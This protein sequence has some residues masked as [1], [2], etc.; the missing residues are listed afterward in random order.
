MYA[1]V[2]VAVIGFIIVPDGV[3]NL[4]GFLGG[5][6]IVEVNQRFLVNLLLQGREIGPQ[7]MWIEGHDRI[8]NISKCKGT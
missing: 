3:D 4:T 6:G 8:M 1:A 5:S 7:H 2:D